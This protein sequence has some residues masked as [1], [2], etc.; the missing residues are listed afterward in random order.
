MMTTAAS[1]AAVK[2]AAK[3]HPKAS[4]QKISAAAAATEA[5]QMTFDHHLEA[6]IVGLDE[7]MTDYT[8]HSILIT[9]DKS[10]RG[11]KEIR[12]YFEAL[13]KGADPAYWAAFKIRTKFVEGDAAFLVWEAKPFVPLAT[14]TFIVRNNKIVTQTFTLFTE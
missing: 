6:F 3:A 1:A 2:D 5:T 12:D 13:I 9:P 14:D 11:I 7:V 10:Y 8:E 4:K